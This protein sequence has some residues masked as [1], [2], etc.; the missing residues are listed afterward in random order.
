MTDPDLVYLVA[1]YDDP[2]N[3][4][5]SFAIVT[6]E[7]AAKEG[8]ARRGALDPMVRQMPREVA[9][10]IIAQRAAWAGALALWRAQ[11]VVRTDLRPVIVVE[12]VTTM[13]PD[14]AMEVG[15]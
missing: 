12:E 11:R 1:N 15:R 7:E 10:Q 13:T 6:R 4:L 9:E 14:S 5:V 3:D 2:V 8:L